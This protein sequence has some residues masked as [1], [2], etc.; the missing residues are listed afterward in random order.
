MFN[1][2]PTCNYYQCFFTDSVPQHD[3]LYSI[4]LS[5]TFL[6]DLRVTTLIDSLIDWLLVSWTQCLSLTGHTR[7]LTSIG[8]LSLSAVCWFDLL[9]DAGKWA[10]TEAE[11]CKWG[12]SFFCFDWMK[13]FD[14]CLVNDN[15]LTKMNPLSLWW[16]NEACVPISPQTECTLSLLS[17][18]AILAQKS[19]NIYIKRTIFHLTEWLDYYW[20]NETNILTLVFKFNRS[21]NQTFF[22][23]LTLRE[24]LT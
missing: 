22:F 4:I 15:K 10:L 11:A 6:T 18:N 12:T 3:D 5:F 2:F 24:T 1:R 16:F 13:A 7:F 19:H 20:I 14:F 9:I 21:S 23:Y 8:C 17:I